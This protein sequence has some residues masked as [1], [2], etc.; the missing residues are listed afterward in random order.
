MGHVYPCYSSGYGE[1]E[2]RPFHVKASA[3]AEWLSVSPLLVVSVVFSSP[4]ISQRITGKYLRGNAMLLPTQ[5]MSI[6]NKLCTESE[7]RNERE[8]IY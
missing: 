8:G 1:N 6:I 4:D 3:A 5:R 7:K 2:F